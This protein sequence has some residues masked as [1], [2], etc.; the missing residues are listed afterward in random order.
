MQHLSLEC[1][2]S[3]KSW[4]TLNSYFCSIDLLQEQLHGEGRASREKSAGS[5]TVFAQFLWQMHYKKY[6]TLKIKVKA[7]EYN[8]RDGTFVAVRGECQHLWTS[9]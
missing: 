3:T 1:R 7:T 4:Y 5:S 6:L 9:P 2:I 8:I